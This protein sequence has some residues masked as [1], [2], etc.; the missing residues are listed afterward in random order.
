M[1]EEK[2]LQNCKDLGMWALCGH[3]IH[4]FAGLIASGVWQGLLSRTGNTRY[5]EIGLCWQEI[6]TILGSIVYITIG[7]TTSLSIHE[8]IH[9]KSLS[10][11]W[12]IDK[13]F[14][15]LWF[16]TVCLSEWFL[17]CNWVDERKTTAN[18]I[19]FQERKDLDD[20]PWSFAAYDLQCSKEIQL[21]LS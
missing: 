11:V 12:T 10:L 18:P 2:I 16:I 9:E 6:D 21:N 5:D 8:N 1:Y 14:F 19:L 17:A 7:S 4:W 20:V 13:S 15:K 3:S